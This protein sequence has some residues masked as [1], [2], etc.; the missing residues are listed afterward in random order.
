MSRLCI[1]AYANYTSFH[2]ILTTHN[3]LSE[4]VHYISQEKVLSPSCIC[5][6]IDDLGRERTNILG[7]SFSDLR[8][9]RHTSV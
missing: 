7:L 9:T 4:C 6:R 2:M 8:I 5:P 3:H 1:H